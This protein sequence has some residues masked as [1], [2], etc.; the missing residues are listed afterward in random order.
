M[1]IS[2]FCSDS[3]DLCDRTALDPDGFRGD[4]LIAICCEG[5]GDGG[6]SG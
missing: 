5:F 3:V 2:V 1:T 6:K 4:I